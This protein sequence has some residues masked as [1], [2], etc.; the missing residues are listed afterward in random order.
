MPRR[1]IMR[2]GLLLAI[3]AG[4]GFEAS[5]VP[6][7]ELVPGAA[8]FDRAEEFAAPGHAV[9]SMTI[10]PRG[11][12]TPDAYTYGGLAVH[13]LLDSKLW[14]HGAVSWA[15]LDPKLAVGA[16][17]WRG[18]PITIGAGLEYLG[19]TGKPMKLTLWFEGELWLEAGSNEQFDLKGND[20][21][22]IDMAPPGSASYAPLAE[23]GDLPIRVDVPTTGWYPIRVGFADGDGSG[24][25]SFT[26]TDSGGAM[27]AWTRARMRT[28]ASALDGTLRTVFGRQILGGG[29]GPAQLPVSIIDGVDL[30][31]E[32]DFDTDPPG[33][34]TNDW[35]ARYAGQLYA[36]APGDYTLRITSDDGN[37]GRLGP[38]TQQMVWQRDFGVGVNRAVTLVEATLAAGWND[39]A[40]DYNEVGGVRALRVELEGPSSD[41]AAV[42]RASLR[43][44]ES[45]D[46]RLA[47]GGDEMDREVLNDGGADKPATAPVT[48]AGY[49]G[50]TVNAIDVTYEID[51]EH[52]DQI[53]ID[54]EAP[55]SEAGPELRRIIRDHV[56]ATGGSHIFQRTISAATADPSKELLG[57]ASNGAW[58]LHVYDDVNGGNHTTLSSAKITLHTSGGPERIARTA[59]WT[60][61]VLDAATAVRAIDR[62]VWDARVPEGASIAVRVGT[63]RQADCGD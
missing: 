14:M 56:A 8:S 12:R 48:F 50:E 39:V 22:F 40:V 52:W 42:P 19:V 5:P 45:A 18:E 20:V 26:H 33:P 11:S 62:V 24:G 49:S 38:A 35:S 1:V 44:V 53:R 43:P 21:A 36:S 55:A 16:G 17:L 28:R 51:S 32:A 60:S 29:V 58:R 47:T 34:G 27:I 63:C 7:G 30:L 41:F 2:H 10:E 4:C 37:R 57:R 61:P 23:S 13:S 3:A 31:K 9:S 59:S 25:F 15:A 6:P 46:D 54:L